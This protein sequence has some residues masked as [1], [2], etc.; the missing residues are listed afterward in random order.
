MCV[1]CCIVTFGSEFHLM[2]P[3]PPCCRFGVL[4][5]R[6]R[7]VGSRKLGRLEQGLERMGWCRVDDFAQ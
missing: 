5:S 3:P 4:M 1:S 6:G 2:H 7:F